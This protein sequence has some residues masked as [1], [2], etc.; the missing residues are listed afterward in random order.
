MN[1]P[2]QEKLLRFDDSLAVSSIHQL[3]H[4]F[5]SH[6]TFALMDGGYFAAFSDIDGNL[7]E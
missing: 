2:N 1:N 4:Q 7:F 3:F 6:F 5:T